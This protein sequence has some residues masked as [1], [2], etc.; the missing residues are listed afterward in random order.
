MRITVKPGLW[1][2]MLL[3][4]I[5]TAGASLS[6]WYFLRGQETRRAQSMLGSASA[7]LQDRV[8]AELDSETAVLQRLA[9]KWQIRPGMSRTEWEYD[10][11]Q[12]LESHPSL[13]SIAWIDATA[14]PWPIQWALP[15]VYESAVSRMHSLIEENRPDLINTVI[16]DQRFRVSEPILV[17]D[18]GKAFAAYFPAVVDGKLKGILVGVFHLQVLMDFIFERLLSSD[19]SLLLLDGYESIYAKG[20]PKNNPRDWEYRG[21]LDIFSSNWQLRMWPN[22][23]V[24]RAN[25]KLADLILMS[26]LAIAFVLT[27]LVYY[28]ARQPAPRKA[29]V[30]IPESSE[31]RR[32][33]SERLKL[34]ESAFSALDEAIFIAEAEK[35]R[36]AGP[37]L[38]FA[39]DALSK[40]TG[41]QSGELV[42]K[43]PRVLFQP[44]LLQKAQAG[45]PAR[46]SLAH[47]SS[48]AVEVDLRVRTLED[49]NHNIT[50]W[51]V[52][53]HRA[54]APEEVAPPV[55]PLSSLLADAPLAVQ[56]LDESGCVLNWN[57]L[58]ESITGF[59]ADS[60]VGHPSPISVELPNSGFWAR[61]DFSLQH[62]NGNSLE[63]TA[64]TAPL[65]G[66]P[67]RYLSLIA[68]FTRDR[69]GNAQLA[70]RESSFRHLLDQSTELLAVFDQDSQIQH[71][72]SAV[73]T[74]LGF[75]PAEL[76]GAAAHE[77][78]DQLPVADSPAEI[79]LR[80]RDGGL[81]P[82]TG[83]MT[84]LEGSPLL[85]FSARPLETPPLLDAIADIVLTY[86]TEHRVTW[87]NRAA[88]ELYGFTMETAR[89]K[90]LGQVQ[91]DWLQVPSRDHVFAALDR[92]GEWR[93][94]ISNFTPSGREVVHD[95]AFSLTRDSA[96]KIT[97]SVAVHRDITTRK[98]AVDALALDEQ[99]RTLTALG[100]TDGLWD[101]NLSSDEVYYSPRWKEMLGYRDEDIAGEVAEW[102]LLVHPDDLPNLRN[103]VAAYL[104]D[105][106][107]PLEM[108]YRA[109]TGG[110]TYRWMLARAVAVRDESGEP[111]RLVGIQ[112]DI[113]EQKQLDEQLLFE[114]FHDSVTGL[115][116][117]AL[118][119]DR[120][121]GELAQASS[122]LAVAFL[123]L[124]NFNAVNEA[125]GT[126]GGDK[127]LAEA[128]QRIAQALPPGSLL[129]RHGS[130]EFVALIPNAAF[131]QLDALATLIR[132]RLNQPFVYQG[133][134]AMLDCRIGFAVNSP[135]EAIGAEALLQAASRDMA[136]LAPAAAA[137]GFPL[138][139]FRVFYHPIVLLESGEIIG[140][141][142][143]IRWQHPQQGL[144]TPGEF[145][146]VAEQSGQILEIDRWMLREAAAKLE[147]L[148]TRYASREALTLTVNLSSRHFLDADSTAALEAVVQSTGLDP[149][150]FRI[151]LY[152]SPAELSADIYANLRRLR[153]PL[154]VAGISSESLP[155]LSR[156]RAGRIKLPRALV[157]G[158]ATGR[159]VEKVRSII[160]M[161]RRENLQVVAE[162]VETL[163]QL[164]VLRELKC[165]LA[166]GFYFTQPTS[167]A[168]TDRLLARSPRW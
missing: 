141:E 76:A 134:Q 81:L 65:H 29:A 110:G 99:T 31:A 72:N 21:T 116:N 67:R 150:R 167:D 22:P 8:R 15:T 101:W 125:I 153:I 58:A 46:I 152:E 38:L 120:L 70:E 165:H 12:I 85:L 56:V 86:D 158:L 33:S 63:L 130:D 62:Q 89:G 104:Q 28:A 132:S 161:A 90:T 121:Q 23:E 2:V 93:G 131:S 59:H 105:P 68:D 142:A 11:R 51:I 168:D 26:G 4:F 50:H 18:R 19:Y 9:D 45:N 43:S 156:F 138:E 146:P 109:R 145:L 95:V 20:I 135:G 48:L 166:Q 41:Y 126:R 136:S 83:S 94:E 119:L 140:M 73:R 75:E 100:A 144:L 16:R 55:E 154:N 77:I 107:T 117:R 14:R 113:H 163:E 74:L 78:L 32:Q 108:E 143:L 162:G 96:G 133:T 3:V 127:A 49:S 79:L 34:W 42:G 53:L 103:R 64:W 128:G 149:S 1:L 97:G 25:E 115:A 47:R 147:E 88:E 114:A 91:P 118:F 84:P 157:Q 111:L 44:E 10:A 124:N 24:Q 98:S 92:D 122:N 66:T 57:S 112:S 139:Q 159:N 155:D 17:A 137:P 60:V 106:S 36:G 37:I 123:D 151:E 61:E 13:L 27:G 160:G 82:M 80:H 102:Q 6:I 35:V 52:A 148:N 5:M 71:V 54:A 129:A 69:A 87:M 7:S 164:A 39:N 40:L 30:L